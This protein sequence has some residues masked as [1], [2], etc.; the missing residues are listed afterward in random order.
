VVACLCS[1]RAFVPGHDRGRRRRDETGAGELGSTARASGPAIS[2]DLRAR[3]NVD[4]GRLRR[5]HRAPRTDGIRVKVGDAVE[6]RHIY[7]AGTVEERLATCTDCSP[8]DEVAA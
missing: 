1:E 3:G 6:K 4:L 2:S 7:T 8:T 5:R